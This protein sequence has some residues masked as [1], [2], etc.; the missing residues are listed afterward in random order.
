MSGDDDMSGDDN[1]E[2]DSMDDESDDSGLPVSTSVLGVL[3][4]LFVGAIGAVAVRLR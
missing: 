2:D 1:M 4:L 3:A